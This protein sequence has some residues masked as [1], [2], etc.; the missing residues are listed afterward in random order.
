M[1]ERDLARYDVVII[2]G[3]FSGAVTALL[4][5]RQRPALRVLIVE[6]QAAFDANLG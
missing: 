1:H 3:A 2:G 4:L 5:R 6:K